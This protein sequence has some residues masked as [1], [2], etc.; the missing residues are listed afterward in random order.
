MSSR[1]AYGKCHD[2]CSLSRSGYFI[3]VSTS[4]I[5][6]HIAWGT[7]TTISLDDFFCMLF[8][9]WLMPPHLF[10][11]FYLNCPSL[12]ISPLAHLL[13]YIP[14]SLFLFLAHFVFQIAFL[15]FLVLFLVFPCNLHYFLWLPFFLL[16]KISTKASVFLSKQPSTL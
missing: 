8:I 7:I 15:L 10:L 13:P 3:C 16:C 6:H 2:C 5:S 9:D 14:S 12:F 1:L 4:H 11:F